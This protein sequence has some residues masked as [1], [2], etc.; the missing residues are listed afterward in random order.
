MNAWDRALP[1]PAFMCAGAEESEWIVPPIAAR[2]ALTEIFAP[3]GAGKSVVVLAQMV[4]LA[5]T[6][7]RVLWLDRDNSPVTLRK[8]LRGLGAESV[9]TF[10]VLARDEAPALADERTWEKFPQGGWDVIVLDSWDTFAEGVGEQDSRR[11]TLALAPLLNVA[12][13]D[14]AP[15]VVVLCNVIKSGS[16]GRGSGVLEDR[17]DNV[18]EARD[19]TG[20]TPSGKRPWWEELPPA[21]RGDWATRATRRTTAKAERIRVAFIATKFRDETDPD[22]FVLEMDF[23][24]TQW[25]VHEVTSELREVGAQ[26]RAEAEAQAK[27]AEDSAGAVL[28][29]ETARRVAVAEKP[30]VLRSAEALLCAHGVTRAR[31][32]AMLRERARVNWR[33]VPMD[34]KS[35]AVMPLAPANGAINAG[36]SAQSGGSAEAHKHG[37]FSQPDCADRMNTGRRNVPARATAKTAGILNAEIAPASQLKHSIENDTELL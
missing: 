18:F 9:T 28:V 19:A 4:D 29:A 15:A 25:T 14:G 2:G 8:R 27:A 37:G 22:P 16:H 6:G 1:A 32:R 20:F 26:A 30:L 21:A 13:R 35:I 11:S 12:R 17:A 10:T 33:L 3:R 7:L 31:A 34:E 36:D 23:T 5:R 24:A